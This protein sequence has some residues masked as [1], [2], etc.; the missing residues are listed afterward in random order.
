[1]DKVLGKHLE[2]GDKRIDFLKNNC[3]KVEEKGYMKRFTS[4]QLTQMKEN[5]S[6]TDIEI[7]DVEEEK[8]EVVRGY[9]ARLDPLTDERKRLLTGLKNKAE[10]VTEIC[11][12][13]VDMES[14][15]TGYYNED[16]DLIESRPAYP[17]EM[18]GN[19]FQMGRKTG[20]ND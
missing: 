16:G 20:T 12:K 8:K 3:D 17:D 10:Y 1:M 11:F 14:R 19:I 6:E 4:D 18:Q 13:F 9:K 5:L 7:N 2:A 15:E